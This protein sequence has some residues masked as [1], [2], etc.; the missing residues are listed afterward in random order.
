[1]ARY[2]AG[3]FYFL[4]DISFVPGQVVTEIDVRVRYDATLDR[5]S[6]TRRTNVDVEPTDFEVEVWRTDKPAD[7]DGTYP[8]EWVAAPATLL[9]SLKASLDACWDD[10][11]QCA[12]EEAA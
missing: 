3:Y 12:Y 1:M 4:A 5:D 6:L 9:P 2:A 7:E 8:Q 11:I 10:L